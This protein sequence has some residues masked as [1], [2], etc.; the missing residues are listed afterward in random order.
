MEANDTFRGRYSRTFYCPY[1]EECEHVRNNA[2]LDCMFRHNYGENENKV[3][4]PN[5]V[6]YKYLVNKKCDEKLRE[7]VTPNKR[8]HDDMEQSSSTAPESARSLRF[9]ARQLRC[10]NKECRFGIHVTF[11]Q[12]EK[13]FATNPDNQERIEGYRSQFPDDDYLCI[14]CYENVRLD[15]RVPTQ[16]EFGLL[17]SCSHIH[18][19]RCMR[20]NIAAAKENGR[21][22]VCGCRCRGSTKVVYQLYEGKINDPE[23]KWERFL[24]EPL[25]EIRQL[26]DETD[27]DSENTDDI[28]ADLFFDSDSITSDSSSL[29]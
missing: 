20:S 8:N 19:A 28:F 7:I 15:R 13:G 4:L 21:N 16:M 5:F 2:P 27:D 12:L 3:L 17:N 25:I 11:Q 22:S 26:I 24:K 10:L 18:C 9:R 23:E 29:D 6:C 1:G 14:I